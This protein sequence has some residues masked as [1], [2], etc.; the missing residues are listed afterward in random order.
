[1]I[2]EVERRTYY[3]EKESKEMNKER[4][5]IPCNEAGQRACDVFADVARRLLH[6]AREAVAEHMRVSTPNAS[7]VDESAMSGGAYVV[8]MTLP[9]GKR[10]T[11]TYDYVA[12]EIVSI[13]EGVT[14]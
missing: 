14:V 1:M 6:K 3:T 12:K 13:A 9:S 5:E 10:Q 11:I 8:V 2:A 4:I 7:I